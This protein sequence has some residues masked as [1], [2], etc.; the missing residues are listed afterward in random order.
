MKG[1]LDNYYLNIPSC[2]VISEILD[3]QCRTGHIVE[4]CLPARPLL[5]GPKSKLDQMVRS[6]LDGN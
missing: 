1:Y 5:L 2:A 3:D 6:H 4:V